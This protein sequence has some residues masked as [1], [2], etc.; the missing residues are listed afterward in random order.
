M[1]HAHDR[2]VSG[3]NNFLLGE[4][5]TITREVNSDTA[6]YNIID[7]SSTNLL[8]EGPGGTLT[9]SSGGNIF[10]SPNADGEFNLDG[11]NLTSHGY[12]DYTTFD[13][14]SELA[15]GTKTDTDSVIDFVYKYG[16]GAVY[17]STVPLDF[18]VA[19]YNTAK[20][21]AK[22]SLHYA[23]SLIFDGYSTIK[24]TAS[25]D[26][27]YGTGGDDVI[28]G[29]G[30][31]DT[32]WGGAGAD[33]FEYTA[34]TDSSPDSLFSLQD[35]IL[36]FNSSEDSIDVSAITNSVTKVLSGTELQLDTDGDGLTDDMHF[37]L[38]GFT[39]TVDDVTV[40]T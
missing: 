34:T 25:A 32:L 14:T 33:V 10:S 36:D 27:I 39:G 30:D 24:G 19:S 4:T 13:L 29:G 37:N 15:L 18:Y 35:T 6:N 20:A 3:A 11:G 1:V 17:Y 26:N 28:W 12:A 22:N 2:Y 31:A 5:A 40:V 8:R 9:D 16:S 7:E 21:Y 38:T 23:T